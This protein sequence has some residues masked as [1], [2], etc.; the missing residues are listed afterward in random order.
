MKPIDVVKNNSK[1]NPHREIPMEKN[2][3]DLG[4]EP[5]VE[6]HSDGG[7]EKE[8]DVKDEPE[9]NLKGGDIKNTHSFQAHKDIIKA[10]KYIH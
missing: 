8:N 10:I 7:S 5:G 3:L 1:R 4:T 9:T 6:G 2:N